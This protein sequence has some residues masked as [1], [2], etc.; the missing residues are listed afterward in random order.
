MASDGPIA[1]QP[2]HGEIAMLKAQLTDIGYTQLGTDSI[3]DERTE[4]AIKQIQRKY[5]LESDGIVGPLT[6]IVL[7]NENPRLDIPHIRRD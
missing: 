3:Y 2:S 5:G 1:R 6:K 7:F 4:E